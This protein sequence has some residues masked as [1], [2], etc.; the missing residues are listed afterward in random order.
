MAA[1]KIKNKEIKIIITKRIETG[2]IRANT[3]E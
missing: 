1:K 3:K 2:K